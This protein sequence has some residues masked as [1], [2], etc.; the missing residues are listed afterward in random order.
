VLLGIQVA[1]SE[2]EACQNLLDELGYHYIEETENK[3]YRLF[4]S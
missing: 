3:A 4:L 2:L 1:D